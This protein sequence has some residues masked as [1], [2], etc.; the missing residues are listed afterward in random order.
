[1][2]PALIGADGFGGLPL[3]C[4]RRILLPASVVLRKH[5]RGDRPF[6]L[7]ADV[8]GDD[9]ERAVLGSAVAGEEPPI[10]ATGGLIV[11]GHVVLADLAPGAGGTAAATAAVA[12]TRPRL[13]RMVS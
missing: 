7:P 9:P 8:V 3:S 5:H 6:P 2:A 12:T 13:W 4:C 1:M 11:G 10:A